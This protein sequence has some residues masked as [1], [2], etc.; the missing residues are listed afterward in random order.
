MQ[1]C[2]NCAIDKLDRNAQE[3][4]L[5][6]KVEHTAEQVG[7]MPVLWTIV[8]MDKEKIHVHVHVVTS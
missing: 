4:L 3:V 2:H 6:Q 5:L 1:A 8:T 7:N